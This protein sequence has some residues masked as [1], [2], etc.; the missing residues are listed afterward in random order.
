M[1]HQDTKNTK[2]RWV[3]NALRAFP[4][5]AWCSW[6]LG[7]FLLAAFTATAYAGKKEPPPGSV[8]YVKDGAVWRAPLAAPDQPT[9][10]ADVAG[11]AAV[12]H[13]A[14]AADG[15]ALLIDL[16][17]NAI[18]IDLE[19]PE[20]I[21][22]PCRGGRISADGHRVLCAARG[23]GAVVYRVRPRLGSSPLAGVDPAH[24]AAAGERVI[25]EQ[26]GHLAALGGDV[27]APE[28][29]AADFSIAPDGERA[30]GRYGEGD[31]ESLYGFRLDGRATRRKL[32]PGTPV[33]W[34]SDST[35]LALASGEE[36]CAVRAAGGEYKCWK[37]YRALA[38]GPGGA[39]ALVA[40]PGEDGTLALFLAPTA[41][42][43]AQRPAP[44]LPSVRGA[45]LLP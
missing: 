5:P 35:W 3:G 41:G 29:P 20:P 23:S 43:R 1:N 27:V 37:G 25:V 8:A 12:V 21:Y 34:S 32:M 36:A 39:L 31:E 42:A 17:D 28:A 18:W 2:N 38:I 15:T 13:M 33:A 14:A 10:L 45:T 30:V 7:G 44:L 26:D 4:T 16:G 24:V 22:L 40:Q 11:A 6:C 9:K 19:K